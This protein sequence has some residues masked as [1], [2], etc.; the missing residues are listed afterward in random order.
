MTFGTLFPDLNTNAF[1]LYPIFDS[2]HEGVTITDIDGRILYMNSAQGKID[3]I[4]PK[5]ALGKTVTELYRVD[6]GVSPTIQC[7]RTRTPVTN[8][9][10][11]YRTHLG[12]IV[13]SIHNVYPLVANDELYGAIIFIKDYGLLTPQVTNKPLSREATTNLDSVTPVTSRSRQSLKNGTRFTFKDIIGTSHKFIKAIQSAEMASES[14]SPV[15]FYGETGT[16]K[17]LFAQSIHNNSSRKKSEYVALNCAAIPEN[18]LEGILFGTTRGAFT[19]AVDKQGLFEQANGGTL[20]L[21]EVN[22]MALGLQAKI[23]RVLQEK[24]VRRIG[25][26]EEV[27]IDIKLISSVNQDPH[28]SIKEGSLRP[29]LM[30]RLGVVFIVIPPLR[31]RQQDIENLAYYFLYECNRLLHKNIKKISQE[32]VTLFKSYPWPGNVRE[33][34]HV[35]EGAANMMQKNDIL[36]PN[37]L[38]VHLAGKKL[39]DL[40][41][42][43]SI[44]TDNA[45]LQDFTTDRPN[46]RG[47]PGTEM[48]DLQVSQK[49]FEREKIIE[50]LINTEGNAS[51]AARKLGMS[52]QLMHYKL[53]RY[54]I[55]AKHYK[56]VYHKVNLK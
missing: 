26:L 34:E 23:L 25:A 24:K 4:I 54:S 46:V 7:L 28:E 39:Q 30:Y 12:R 38:T 35:I 17:E 18:L 3:D 49:T 55:N 42:D 44:Q 16:G 51:Q 27:E 48:R 56:V 10:V 2:F 50:T 22:S 43:E 21:D 5:E 36:E 41:S 19:G 47:I 29:D 15:M 14:P 6:E 20:F 33:L 31:E 32:V 37:H 40:Q 13:N 11:F 53:K 8:L 52:P 45:T 1:S 9:A